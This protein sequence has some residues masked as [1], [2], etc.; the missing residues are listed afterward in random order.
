M[1]DVEK[2]AGSALSSLG[3]HSIGNGDRLKYR[4]QFACAC[5]DM[6]IASDFPTLI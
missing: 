3:M 5:H 1:Y 6:M 2:A 4:L